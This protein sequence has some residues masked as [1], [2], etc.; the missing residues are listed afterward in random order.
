VR[1]ERRATADHGP[2]DARGRRVDEE[3]DPPRDRRRLPSRYAAGE[4]G[5]AILKSASMERD[6]GG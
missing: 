1:G 6:P 3:P 4:R 5:G 2:C